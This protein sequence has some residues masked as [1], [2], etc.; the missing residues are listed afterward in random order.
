VIAALQ[1]EA[2][3]VTA[4]SQSIGSMSPPTKLLH[5][6][7]L[8]QEIRAGDNE[9]LRWQFTNAAVKSDINENVKVAK[10]NPNSPERVDMVVATIMA[11]GV[12]G[13]H[14]TDPNDMRIEIL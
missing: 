6:K 11:F 8:R 7:I 2:L 3:P 1:Y 9:A 10:P 12:G 13:S 4:Y 14:I 5:T